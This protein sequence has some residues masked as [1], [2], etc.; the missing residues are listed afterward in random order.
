MNTLRNNIAHGNDYNFDD[1]TSEW[2]NSK[3]GKTYPVI[4]FKNIEGV[5]RTL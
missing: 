2:T 4:S 1:F 5:G 3:T